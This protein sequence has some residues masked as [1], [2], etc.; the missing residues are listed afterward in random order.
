MIVATTRLSPLAPMVLRLKA[1][2]A[3]L[4]QPIEADRL[5][6]RILEFSFVEASRHALTQI[7]VEK[8]IKIRQG[9]L[10]MCLVCATCWDSALRLAFA[11]L[12]IGGCMS[13]TKPNSTRVFCRLSAAPSI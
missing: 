9:L 6:K 7:L 1:A 10:T 12:P 13:R 11:I 3:Q 8:P 5:G 4:T 2:I